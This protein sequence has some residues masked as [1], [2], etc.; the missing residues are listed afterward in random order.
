MKTITIDEIIALKPCLAYPPERVRKLA[1]MEPGKREWTALEIL[2]RTDIPAEHRLWLVHREALIDTPIL[3]E[4]A[5]RYAERVLAR[6]PEPDPISVDLL[7]L[8]RRWVCGEAT[9]EELRAAQNAARDATV[10]A[11]V[12]AAGYAAGYAAV[13]AARYAATDAASAVALHIT[14]NAA[15]NAAAAAAWN[16]AVYAAREAAEA[17]AEAAERE[18]QVEI[19]RGLLEATA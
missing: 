3:H 2:A 7:A 15:R 17:A 1:D 14:R 4:A 19:L 6:L 10:Y 5:C 11:A 9:D 16:A 13:Y 18:A 12:Y 8:K